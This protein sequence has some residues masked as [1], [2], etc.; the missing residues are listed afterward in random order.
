VDCTDKVRMCVA[1]DEL[2]ALLGHADI[3]GIDIPIL[4]FANKM[5]LPSALTPVDCMQVMELENIHD[6][7]W[8]IT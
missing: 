2:D 4:F 1:K 3:A 5:D 6:K 8:H 7:A